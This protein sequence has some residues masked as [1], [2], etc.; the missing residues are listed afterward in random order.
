MNWLQVE[1]TVLLNRVRPC[2][3]SVKLNV[4]NKTFTKRC[5]VEDFSHDCMFQGFNIDLSSSGN[6][7]MFALKTLSGES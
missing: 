3:D 4:N 2:F 7:F 6:R 1:A 5:F